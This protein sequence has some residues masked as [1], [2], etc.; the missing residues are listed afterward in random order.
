MK[1]LRRLLLWGCL[2]GYLLQ[3]ATAI[4]LAVRPTIKVRALPGSM[5]TATLKKDF[6]RF[7]FVPLL[8]IVSLVDQQSYHVVLSNGFDQKAIGI[9]IIGDLPIEELDSFTEGGETVVFRRERPGEVARLTSAKRPSGK[10]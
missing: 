3:V 7:C 4:D 2:G 10:P 6:D 1:L 8:G 9:D 5:V